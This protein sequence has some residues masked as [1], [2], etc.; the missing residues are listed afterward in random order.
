MSALRDIATGVLGRGARFGTFVTLFY[1]AAFIAAAAGRCFLDLAGGPYPDAGFFPTFTAYVI[2]MTITGVTT[3]LLLGV[4]SA[5][6]GIITLAV[7]EMLYALAHVRD[8]GR[9]SILGAAATSLVMAGVNIVVLQLLAS[10]SIEVPWQTYLFW[11]GLPSIIY[12]LT[13]SAIVGLGSRRQ[14]K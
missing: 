10:R 13:T 9:R 8:P 1:A 2:A 7:L 3:A 12:V 4:I 6:V 14:I 11:L 5:I